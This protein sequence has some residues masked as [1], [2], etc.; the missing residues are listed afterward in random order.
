MSASLKDLLK[1]IEELRDELENLYEN[2]EFKDPEIIRKSQEIDE[3]LN[4]YNRRIN[5]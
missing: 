3:K 2:R 1:D 5:D 4:E